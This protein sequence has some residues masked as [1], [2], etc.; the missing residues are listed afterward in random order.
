MLNIDDIALKLP[1]I[2]G[3]MGIGVSLSSLAGAVSLNGGLGVISAA[4]PGFKEPDFFENPLKAN[5]RAL[6]EHIRIAKE[7]SNNAPIGVNIMVAMNNYTEYV[8]SAVEGNADVIISGA[9]LP[10]NL[11]ELVGRSKTKIAPIISSLKAGSVLLKLW[12]RRYS[13]TADMVVVEGPLA[14]G[15]LGFTN[16]ELDNPP[17]MEIVLTEIKKL[18]K[19]Y[20]DKYMKK[21]PLVFAGGVFTREDVKHLIEDIGVDGVQVSTKFVTTNECDA[22][23]NFK[24]AYIDSSESDIVVVKS[25]VGMPGRAIRNNFIKRVELENEKI[26]HCYGCLHTCDPKTIPYCISQALINAAKGDT[27]N[28]LIFCGSN[29]YKL[30]EI[31]TVK[32]VLTDLV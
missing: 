13:R 8:K 27:D 28:G 19:Q 4:Q 12:D 17:N 20:E 24:N 31:T 32:D 23:I 6:K 2:Q 18:I 14:G 10:V 30:N 26:T 16:Q 5:L 1:V 3:G 7:I 11:P 21:I 9:G 15:H 22:H 25:P 29:A